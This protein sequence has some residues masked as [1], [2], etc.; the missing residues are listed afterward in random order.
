MN[1]AFFTGAFTERGTEVA[2]FA[3]AKYN[4][5]I[6]Q[7]KSIIVYPRSV[8]E[9]DTFDKFKNR[10]EMIEIEKVE[11]MEQVIPTR[12]I[13]VFYVLTHGGS[14]DNRYAMKQDIWGDCSTLVQ[15]VFDTTNPQGDHY[16][17]IS[18]TL[19]KKY[20]T[21]V[22]VIPHIVERSSTKANL[23][24]ELGLGSATVFGRYGGYGQ[25]DN[26]FA[27]EAIRQYLS[28]DP[29]AYFLF[30][31]T[32]KFY[33]HPRI[34]Y[35][36]KTIDVEYKEKFVN[37]CDAM[38]HARNLGETFGLSVA[39]FAIQ[40]KPVITF[41]SS[42]DNAHLDIL[43]KKAVIYDSVESLVEIFEQLPSIIPLNDWTAYDEF[44]PERV[45]PMFVPFFTRN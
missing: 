36:E 11:D 24:E 14:W 22:P 45:M 37:T 23:R 3:Y 32:E 12:G 8:T 17:A 31:N 28:K 21:S 43:G 44:T 2:L 33:T 26:A 20:N 7:N 38:I 27:H 4:E 10:F 29:N 25:F 9:K 18:D 15:C 5:E 6:L 41:R 40:N 16:L 39:E 35:L 42:M 13:Q 34:L 19:N 1:I 30:M